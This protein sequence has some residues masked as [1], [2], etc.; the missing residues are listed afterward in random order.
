MRRIRIIHVANVIAAGRQ[1]TAFVVLHG[2][3]RHSCDGRLVLLDCAATL[4][5]SHFVAGRY[6][7]TGRTGYNMESME[8]G[9]I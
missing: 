9:L 2:G 6:R 7:A 4:Q 5:Y 1:P 3:G 8:N